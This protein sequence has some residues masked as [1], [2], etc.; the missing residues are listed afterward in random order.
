MVKDDA[1]TIPIGATI[2]H[3]GPMGGYFKEGSDGK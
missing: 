1:L 3:S 2:V